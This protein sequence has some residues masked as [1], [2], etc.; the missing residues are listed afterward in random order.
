MMNKLKET[1][2]NNIL[3][4]ED[5]NDMYDTFISKLKNI[6]NTTCPVTVTKQTLVRK[7]PDK[8]WMTNS[9]KQACTKKN[10]LYRQF[11]KKI[12]V[13]CEEIYNKY[14]NKLTGLL[15]YCEQ[16]LY[17]ASRKNKGNIK[18]TWKI[19][20]CLINKKSKGTSYPTEFNSSAA[21]VT[22]SKHIANSF[23]TFCCCKYWTY[24]G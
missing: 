4:S 17:R 21:K 23:N 20:N 24:S 2:W 18:E 14:K 22:G 10:L 19:I 3:A 5:V 8:P 11:L 13:T 15:R 6:Y 16:T 9:L 1:N 7:M 12:S